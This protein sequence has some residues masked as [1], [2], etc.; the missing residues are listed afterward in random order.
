MLE[1]LHEVWDISWP[2]REGMVVYPGDPEVTS[3]PYRSLAQ[4]QGCN[5][6]Q[7]RL[8]THTGTH[9]DA[10]RH[11]L[12]E[13]ETV[14]RLAWAALLGPARLVQAPAGDSIGAD[15]IRSLRL[16]AGSRLLLRTR[17]P[18]EPPPAEF[19]PAWPALTGEAATE[20]ARAGVIL[21]G[22]D[23]P[24]VDAFHGPEPVVHRTLLG[25]GMALVE[26]ADLSAPPE[27]QYALLCLP[28]RVADGDGA[29]CR[30]VLVR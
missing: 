15:F 14:D 12:A 30:A 5:L 8:G 22:V 21:L 17:A 29:P 19:P 3:E 11:F 25:A 7:M 26:N 16:P 10:P 2:L 13:G 6:T 18:G 23:T 4:G 9:V 28:L 27:G 24:S 20:I 1:N